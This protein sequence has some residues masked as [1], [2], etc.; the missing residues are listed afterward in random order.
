MTFHSRTPPTLLR[1]DV[2]DCQTTFSTRDARWR[3]C[4]TCRA[5]GWNGHLVEEARTAKASS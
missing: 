3:I 1:C 2:P 4:P 5:A